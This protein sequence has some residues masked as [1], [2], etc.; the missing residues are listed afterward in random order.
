M[1][2]ETE[3]QNDSISPD[4]FCLSKQIP[5]Q[6]RVQGAQL[7]LLTLPLDGRDSEVTLQGGWRVKDGGKFAITGAALNLDSS[8]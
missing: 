6:P 2:P 1:T 5:G 7:Y 4:S 8:T 3:V